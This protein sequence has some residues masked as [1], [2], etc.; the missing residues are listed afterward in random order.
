MISL[1]IEPSSP[2]GKSEQ[3]TLDDVELSVGFG[4]RTPRRVL[5]RRLLPSVQVSFVVGGPR[6]RLEPQGPVAGRSRE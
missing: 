2:K 4:D 3:L 6:G 5:H 1:L